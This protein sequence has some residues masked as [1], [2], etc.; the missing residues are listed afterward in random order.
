[1]RAG[2]ELLQVKPKE[3]TG[4]NSFS[5][6]P[7]M[8]YLTVLHKQGHGAPPQGICSKFRC[9][10]WRSP[11][12]QQGFQ[13]SVPITVSIPLMTWQRVWL[14]EPADPGAQVRKMRASGSHSQSSWKKTKSSN[15]SAKENSGRACQHG[16]D[17]SNMDPSVPTAMV[18]E[19][20]PTPQGEATLDSLHRFCFFNR[21]LL[22]VVPI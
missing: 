2:M 4:H 18:M 13:S 3:V 7:P 9:Q 22:Y 1:M 12:W 14:Q 11:S 6:R 17:R 10:A 20:I 16:P 8:S 19:V 5:S 15:K 21:R